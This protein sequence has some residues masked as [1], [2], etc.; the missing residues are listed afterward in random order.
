MKDVATGQPLK[1]LVTNDGKLKANGG[2][3]ELTAAAA[4]MVVDSVINNKGVIEA[5]SIGTQN[6][7]IVL[8]AATAR[9]KPAGAPTQTV[10]VSGTLTAAGKKHARHRRGG[11]DHRHRREHPGRRRARSTLRQ[12]PAAARC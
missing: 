11:T 10:K 1:S 6:G 8:G 7:M 9:T 12:Q 5:N 4:R 3:V 2:R